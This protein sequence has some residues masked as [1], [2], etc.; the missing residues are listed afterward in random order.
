MIDR[1]YR[2]FAENAKG[3]ELITICGNKITGM[4]FS[5][6]YYKQML[7]YGDNDEEHFIITSS[8]C[9]AY[10]QALEYKRVIPETLGQC[11]TIPDKNGVMLFEGDIVQAAINGG[12]WDA[13]KFPPGVITFKNGAFGIQDKKLFTPLCSYSPRVSFEKLGDI[14]SNPDLLEE[15]NK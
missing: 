4:W 1:V 6:C 7:Y 15:V 11:S 2:G 14:F 10:D 12:T 13:F 5:G 8:E 3:T 9:L